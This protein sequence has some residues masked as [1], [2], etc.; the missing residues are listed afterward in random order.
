MHR[1]YIA[2]GSNLGDRFGNIASAL[3]LLCDPSCQVSSTDEPTHIQLVQTSYL[4]ETAPMYV[5]DQPRFLN[6]VVE[7]STKLTPHSLL[8]RL[9]HVEKTLGRDAQGI[10]NGPRPVDLDI[11]LYESRNDGDDLTPTVVDTLDLA[12]PHPRMVDREFVL[13]PL[14]ELITPRVMHP[15]LNV[16]I[17]DLFDRLIRAQSDAEEAPAVRV[18]PLPRGRMLH[19]NQTIV[20]GILN[21]TPDSFSDGGKLKGSV[22]TATKIALQMEQEGAGII[23]VGGES[24]RPGAKEVLVEEELMRTIPVIQDIRK[25]K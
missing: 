20:M 14:C 5:T 15:V 7:V 22:Q 3:E 1:A 11:V 2:V 19:F 13:R 17:S 24:T 6:G 23:D 10:R 9:K 18:L 21:V 12:I 25:G 4:H 8:R 16:T